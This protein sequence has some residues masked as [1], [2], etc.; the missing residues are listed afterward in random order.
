MKLKRNS[1]QS[2]TSSLKHNMIN[3]YF[4]LLAFIILPPPLIRIFSETVHFVKSWIYFILAIYLEDLYPDF[5]SYKQHTRQ[6]YF[7]TMRCHVSRAA[8]IHCRKC[9]I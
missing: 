2:E 9:R 7:V 3:G 6:L 5:L 4:Y 1:V 8:T